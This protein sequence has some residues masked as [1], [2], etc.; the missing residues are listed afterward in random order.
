MNIFHTIRQLLIGQGRVSKY[1]L[2]AFGEIILVMIGI[3]LALKVNNWN[4]TRLNHL[5]EQDYL[6]R[7]TDEVQADIDYYAGIRDRFHSKEISLARIIK[8]WQMPQPIITDSLEYIR[9]FVS[10]GNVGPWFN[11]PV[12]WDQLIQTGDLN[13]IRDNHLVEALYNYHNLVK[14]TSDNYLIYPTQMTNRARESWSIPFR[15]EPL[16]SFNVPRNELK[17]PSKEVFENIWNN[18]RHFLDLYIS[19]EY[20]TSAQVFNMEDIITAGKGLLDLL[21]EKTGK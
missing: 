20:I 13:L 3:L 7:M 4:S 5:K 10:A 17:I 12:T 14:R 2:Y 15:Q 18:R 1:L 16:E 19:L 6:R 9:D 21:R 8:V 11:E